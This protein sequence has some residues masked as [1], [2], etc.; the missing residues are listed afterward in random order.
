MPKLSIGKKLVGGFLAVNL[1]IGAASLFEIKQM[2]DV[3]KE[4][5]KS[6]TEVL[7]RIQA[8]DAMSLA[9][10][11]VGREYY[12]QLM[13]GNAAGLANDQVL[14][15]AIASF[16]AA[17]K[18]LENGASEAEKPEL[19]GVLTEWAKLSGPDA[20]KMTPAESAQTAATLQKH[21]D[22]I[23]NISKTHA[24]EQQAKTND[25]FKKA[26]TETLIFA[27]VVMCLGLVLGWRLGRSI[28]NGFRVAVSRLGSAS[29]DLKHSKDQITDTASNTAHRAEA[30]T[31]SAGAVS[32]NVNTVA[33][34]VEEMR[35]SIQ[36]IASAANEARTVANDGVE[37]VA[38]T[39][40]RVGALGVSSAEIGKVIEVITSIAEQ[41]NLLALNATIEAARA[42]EAGKGFAVVANE[43]KELARQT[44]EATDEIGQKVSAIQNDAEGAVDAISK[45]STV[46]SRIHDIQSNIASAVEEQTATTSEIAAS[47]H[48]AAVGAG[49]ISDSMS[50]VND[51]ARDTLNE[52]E[53]TERVATSL[54]TI[55]AELRNLVEGTSAAAGNYRISK[56]AHVQQERRFNVSGGA[57]EPAASER[58]RQYDDANI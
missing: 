57:H 4:N 49:E 15:D 21:I 27:A 41:T 46:I 52:A 24:A 42:G 11:N 2:N 23:V 25:Q 33:A 30:L 37:T 26:A 18:Q 44:A 50:A 48:G 3:K 16:T 36:G 9:Y 5:Q 29:S 55:S 53:S 28:T 45:I 7:A 43:V 47:I 14:N 51:A 17:E 58:A 10:S 31:E 13:S 35:A 38:L 34:A 22:T 54:A 8:A 32:A 19:T 40:E 56:S 1:L 39:N 20:A 6:N 12:L